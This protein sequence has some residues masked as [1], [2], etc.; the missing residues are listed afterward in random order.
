MAAGTLPAGYPPRSWPA[1]LTA[2]LAQA[3]AG[4]VL[5]SRH[6]FGARSGSGLLE[7]KRGEGHGKRRERALLLTSDDASPAAGALPCTTRTPHG[8]HQSS[9]PAVRV[10]SV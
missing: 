6:G 3:I 7:Q 5:P 8:I 9:W 10:N 1:P 4:L 2:I